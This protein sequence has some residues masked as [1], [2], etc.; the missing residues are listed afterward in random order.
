TIGSASRHSRSSIR[1]TTYRSGRPQSD[2]PATPSHLLEE[3]VHPR[4]QRLHVR[5]PGGLR[6]REAGVFPPLPR[7]VDP[8]GHSGGD[9][10]RSRVDD[11]EVEGTAEG[12]DDG[13]GEHRR[14]EEREEQDP[15]GRRG[16]AAEPRTPLGVQ[17]IRNLGGSFREELKRAC[18]RRFRGLQGHLSVE[19]VTQAVDPRAVAREPW[20][21]SPS[22]D[23]QE[24]DREDQGAG[25]RANDWYIPLARDQIEPVQR[26]E[27]TD[28][29]A[30]QV[31]NAA[32]AVTVLAS[33]WALLL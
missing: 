2:P 16:I 20:A 29:N 6:V 13:V 17:P 33:V 15:Q 14:D 5:V 28:E 23:R 26:D 30:V 24:D 11:Y 19:R 9:G 21:V 25:C 32:T 12:P 3:V 4:T 18:S 8:R 27:Q 22:H 1:A 7:T 10:S 31:V